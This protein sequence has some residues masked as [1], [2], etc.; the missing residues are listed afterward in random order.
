MANLSWQLKISWKQDIALQ[1]FT[2]QKS[3]SKKAE[4]LN[5]VNRDYSY[6]FDRRQCSVSTLS[7]ILKHFNISYIDCRVSENDIVGAVKT[8][9]EI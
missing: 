1:N 9:E 7:R 4:S 5:F 3:S 6:H 2:L 8:E